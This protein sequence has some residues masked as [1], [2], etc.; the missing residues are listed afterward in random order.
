MLCNQGAT[1][2]PCT[3][4]EGGGGGAGDPDPMKNHKNIRSLSNT[5]L[6]PL[7]YHKAAKGS[8]QYWAIIGSL[9]K[10]HLNGASL[11]GQ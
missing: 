7:K 2:N 10:R 4:P 8:I 9:A 1:D 11:A 3:D 6:D 5:G